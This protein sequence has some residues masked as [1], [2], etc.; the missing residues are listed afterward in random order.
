MALLVTNK[1]T[2]GLVTPESGLVLEG[3]KMTPIRVVTKPLIYEI[4]EP[5]T[6]KPCVTS[7]CSDK[8][9]KNNYFKHFESCRMLLLSINLVQGMEK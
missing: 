8:E 3:N 2:A 4:M 7:W 5:N 1:I 6:S 9:N